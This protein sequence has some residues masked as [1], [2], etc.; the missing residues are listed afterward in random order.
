M[1]LDE[2]ISTRSREKKKKKGYLFPKSS[3]GLSDKVNEVIIIM[4]L[5]LEMD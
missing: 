1:V 4:L 3:N 2:A 5:R